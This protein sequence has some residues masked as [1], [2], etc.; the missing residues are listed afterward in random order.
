VR[1]R[2]TFTV[3]PVVLALVAAVAFFA[4]SGGL[5]SGR[6]SPGNNNFGTPS[7]GGRS[8]EAGPA[9]EPAPNLGL[10][11][12]DEGQASVLV[13]GLGKRGDLGTKG[14]QTPVP[15]AS[16][17]KVMTAYWCSR[18]TRC[19]GTSPARTSPSTSPPP[20]PRR[21][22]PPPQHQLIAG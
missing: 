2:F 5:I 22:R 21:P 1:I 3:I 7:S 19:A 14:Q 18:T 11:W 13:E 4:A 8:P 12:P 10:P 16:V 15:I 17:T 20:P 6:G 9:T